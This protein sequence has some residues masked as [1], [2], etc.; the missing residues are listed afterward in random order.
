MEK[1][2]ALA[3]TRARQKVSNKSKNTKWTQEEDDLL[4]NL[5]SSNNNLNSTDLANHFVGK[6]LQ[7][8]NER[9][10]KV[11]NPSLIKGSWT[12][13]EDNTIIKFVAEHGTKNWTKLALLL[14]GRI[15]K[16]CRERWR[17]HLDPEVKRQP[18]TK[19]EDD[20]LIDLHS[21]LGNQWVKIA[22]SLPG[23][24]DNCVKNRWNSTLKKQIYY[25][26]YGNTRP[27]RGRPSSYKV[28][29]S[30]DRS[31]PIPTVDDIPVDRFCGSPQKT[32]RIYSPFSNI[33][34]PF[35]NIPSPSN[36]P[37]S[38]FGYN[39]SPTKDDNVFSPPYFPNLQENRINL[40]NLMSPQK[41]QFIN[42][43]SSIN[44]NEI[45]TQNKMYNVYK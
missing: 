6:T 18:W 7:Q 8:I 10:D 14:P 36:F 29:K 11:L 34:S 19:E 12:L 9:W 35:T 28:S 25:T 23:R 39:W 3:P 2:A 42:N 32:P 31:I 20:I 45:D 37:N 16:Q 1:Q 15:G 27:K 44:N 24:S 33:H 40:E 17:N 43:K 38:P 30:E 41:S 5:M 4:S 21:T 13:E 22:E 26:Q